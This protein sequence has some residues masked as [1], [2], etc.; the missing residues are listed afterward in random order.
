MG[1]D[2][3]SSNS[4][5]KT[6][7]Q[8]D[9]SIEKLKSLRIVPIDEDN[10]Q[11]R[12]RIFYG[13]PENRGHEVKIV[14]IFS[15][16]FIFIYRNNQVKRTSAVDSLKST[17]KCIAA[18][19][20]RRKRGD[21]TKHKLLLCYRDMSKYLPEA[22]PITEEK[23]EPPK[24]KPEFPCHI[25]YEVPDP[26]EPFDPWKPK[27]LKK[28]T[29]TRRFRL[30]NQLLLIYTVTTSTLQIMLKNG[31]KYSRVETLPN[32]NNVYEKG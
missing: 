23:P 28:Y 9:K 11:L 13:T 8:V 3:P 14:I 1:G 20:G 31:L 2:N 4:I 24:K 16:C 10:M 19:P 17:Q 6:D 18:K 7:K 26:D 25:L 30:C 27:K 32:W 12:Y 15:V 5:K 22:A 29:L 21:A